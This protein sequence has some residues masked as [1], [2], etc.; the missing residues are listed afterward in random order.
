MN[1]RAVLGSGLLFSVTILMMT[2]IGGGIVG[3][4]WVFYGQGYDFRAAESGVLF[5]IVL[6]CFSENDFF[7]DEFEI[8]ESCRLNKNVIS[9][10]HLIFI[11]RLSDKKEF[12]VGVKD[13]EMQC[14]LDSRF[15]NVAFPLCINSKIFM[16]GEE[17]VFLVGSN[18]NSE[19]VAV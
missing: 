18:Q 10:N 4:V 19:K 3:G 9:K 14:F 5:E 6:D 13:F 15:D 16:N 17:Y 2:I 12:F 7:Q 1:R 11:K 8:Y